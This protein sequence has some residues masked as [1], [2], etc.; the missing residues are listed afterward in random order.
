VLDPIRS[1]SDGGTNQHVV[2]HEGNWAI[3]T[4]K[5]Q[6]KRSAKTARSRRASWGAPEMELSKR[7]K[8]GLDETRMLILGAQILLGFQFREVFGET[9]DKLPT[10]TRY[11]DGA[12]LAFMTVVVG[13]LIA[14]DTYHRIVMDGRDDP[15]LQWVI[16]VVATSA[17]LPLAIALGI[18]LFIACERMF[19]SGP[20]IAVGA[21]TA[22]LALLGW[23][24]LPYASK[25]SERLVETKMRTPKNT[26]LVTRIEQMLTEARVVLPGAQALMGFQLSIVLTRS[27]DDLS[28]V[29]RAVHAVSLC[30][31]ALAVILLMAPAAYHRI[32]FGGQESEGMHRVGSLMLTA[33][34]LPL[35]GGLAGDL[36]V[37]IGKITQSQPAGIGTG[38]AALLF[39]IGLWYVIP[40]VARSRNHSSQ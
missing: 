25:P 22:V 15:R 39:L 20:G 28:E 40:L 21:S 7:I 1:V 2:P 19:G 17:L 16:N 10:A 35:A 9:F 29:A 23:Y 32:V 33:A 34:T 5:K 36:Y 11:C 30:L 18:D 27:F 12:G 14:P 37:V 4:F 8:I 26:P 38:I 3:K 31:V 24:G 13:L 6:R